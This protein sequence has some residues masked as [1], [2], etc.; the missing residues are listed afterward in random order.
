MPNHGEARS[1]MNRYALA[2]SFIGFALVLLALVWGVSAAG[3]AAAAVEIGPSHTESAL[4]GDDI[5]Y[6]HIL[7]NT[8]T[9]TDTFSLQVSSSQEWPVTATSQLSPTVYATVVDT[10][11]VQLYQLFFPIVPNHW[12]P[13]PYAPI[14]NPIQNA[15]LDGNY[16]VTWSAADLAST[17]SLEEDDNPNFTSPTV[18]FSGAALSWPAANKSPDTYYYRVRG[19]NSYGFGPYSNVQS[20]TVVPPT[21]AAPT[22]NPIENADLDGIYTVSWTSAARAETYSL[23]EDDND[24]FT[25]PTVVFSGSGLSWTAPNRLPGTY[26]YRVRGHNQA[27][28]GPYSNVQSVTV[29]VSFRADNT[30]LT[31]GQC[32]TLRWDTSGIKAIYVTFGYGYDPAGVVGVS[33]HQVCPSVDTTYKA[34]VNF[35][36]NS[37]RTYTVF[38]DVSGTGCADPVIWRFAPTTYQVSP[39]EKFS[40]FWGSELGYSDCA[41][42]RYFKFGYNPEIEVAPIGSYIDAQ[43]YGNTTF[44]LRLH[45]DGWGDAYASFVVT[46]R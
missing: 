18:V 16:T 45:K 26:Y 13:L 40:I 21:P 38:I 7:A 20:V 23:E 41:D 36:D 8:G 15:D 31:V 10:T 4:P 29:K 5:V 44:Q 27:G 37:Q 43:I 19:H 2:S 11:I 17:Y 32:T 14:L 22:L 28:Y 33:S 9:A 12:P 30:T 39:G 35:P 1:R 24:A 34:I 6:N 42:A 25:S 46:I 3:L